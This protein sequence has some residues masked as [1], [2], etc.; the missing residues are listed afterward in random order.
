MYET[1]V[2]TSQLHFPEN[3]NYTMVII[4]PELKE[5]KHSAA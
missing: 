1:V 3:W 5:I 2:Q 4:S